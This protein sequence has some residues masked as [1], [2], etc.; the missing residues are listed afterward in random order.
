[1]AGSASDLLVRMGMNLCRRSSQGSSLCSYRISTIR[2]AALSS[3]PHAVSST[4]A[5]CY[6][7]RPLRVFS[8]GQA[9]AAAAAQADCSPR[10]NVIKLLRQRGLLQDIAN[11][12]LETVTETQSLKLYLGFDPTADS[13]HL[14]HL[15]GILVL[16]WFQRCGHQPL[17]L[18]GGATGRVGDPS[19][20][21]QER[22]V[23]TVEEIERNVAGMQ[24]ILQRL[25]DDR[26]HSA[27]HPVQ[28]LNNLDWFG[29]MGFLQ[30][31]RDVGKFARVN[32][33]MSRESVKQRLARDEGIS[34]T[35]FSYQL[36]QGYDFV[37][38]CRSSGVQL[39]I[40]GS[41]QMG[42]I[43]TGLELARKLGDESAHPL[44]PCYGLVFPLLTTSDGVKMG[45]SAS[46]AIWLAA[47]KLSP[48]KFYQYLVSSVPDTDV[49]RFLKML[50]FLPLEDISRLEHS[51]QQGGS[52]T[53]NT[54]QKLLAEE[55]TRFVHGQQGLQQAL[56]ATQ[57]LAPGGSTKLDAAALEAIA[58]DA[59]AASLPQAEVIDRAL[60][61]VMTAV[62]LQPSKAASR[63]LIK[64]G[65]VRINNLKVQD[66][67]RAVQMEDLI[68][69]R[70]LL[71]SAGKKNKLL[72]HVTPSS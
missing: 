12:Q 14:G 53:P 24:A 31:L 57:A 38:L 65:G 16:K 50:T 61:D 28:F 56:N 70:M 47:D 11:E 63:R 1:M 2:T 60:A 55:V 45:K 17:A 54:A 59:P 39:Q 49:I 23:L 34:F 43:L 6:C 62:G 37:H 46:G 58:E 7:R 30:F 51:M 4:G 36:L 35:E 22:P 52:Y 29:G 66:E 42:N 27:Q 44:P 40:G 15:L 10:T 41:D 48:F 8:C 13:L 3:R 21:S 5:A 69:G 25:L 71:L 68:E 9:A 67:A 26:T 33:M 18:L 20:K 32:I 64:G 72:L 19:G